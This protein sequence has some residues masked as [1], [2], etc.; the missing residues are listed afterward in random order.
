L[1]H[2][3]PS[4]QPWTHKQRLRPRRH[5]TQGLGLDGASGLYRR[6]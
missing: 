1:P 3:L 5:D 2:R 6:A 4:C